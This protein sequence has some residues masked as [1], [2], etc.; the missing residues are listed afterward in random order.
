MFWRR[1]CR[2]QCGNEKHMDACAQRATVQQ[3]FCPMNS[4][5]FMTKGGYF[6][7]QLC[8]ICYMFK[9]KTIMCRIVRPW[10]VVYAPLRALLVCWFVF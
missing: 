4:E 2:E 3:V 1:S 6:Y 5:V 8:K 10:L 7:T 9:N